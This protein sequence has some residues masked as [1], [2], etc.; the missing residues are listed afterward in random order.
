MVIIFAGIRPEVQDERRKPKPPEQER[1]EKAS[2]QAVAL[3]IQ[4]Y[5]QW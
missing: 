2:I 1:G 4:H 3:P 5:I